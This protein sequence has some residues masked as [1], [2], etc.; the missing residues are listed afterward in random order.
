MISLAAAMLVVSLIVTEERY[1]WFGRLQKINF[2]G[3]GLEFAP[4]G[5][6]SGDGA[7]L[8]PSQAQ[9]QATG[10]ATAN[11]RIDFLL[12]HMTGW[13]Q[14][15][16]RDMQFA[17]EALQPLPEPDAR[18]RKTLLEDERL[19]AQKVI[20]PLGRLLTELQNSRG[21]SHIAYLLKDASMSY[22]RNH[23]E[24]IDA[25]RAMARQR[26][27]NGTAAVATE[28]T[29]FF[30]H[31]V[32]S[33]WEALCSARSGYPIEE[34]KGCYASLAEARPVLAQ[35]REGSGRGSG[36]L[37]TT[38]PYA[39]MLS[40]L[41]LNAAGQYEAA[42]ADLSD[43]GQSVLARKDVGGRR[44]LTDAYRALHLAAILPL[45]QRNTLV[46]PRKVLS[47]HQTATRLGVS[48]YT[49]PHSDGGKTSW[50]N[51]SLLLL[52]P[53]AY[54]KS[55]VTIWQ[56][57]AC[58]RQLTRPFKLFMMAQLVLV[59]NITHQLSLDRHFTETAASLDELR[60][61]ARLLL[62]PNFRCLEH[63]SPE[64]ASRITHERVRNLEGVILHTVASAQLLLGRIELEKDDRQNGRHRLCQAKA[65]LGKALAYHT[66]SRPATPTD[67]ERTLQ[68][69][70]HQW[71]SEH[72]NLLHTEDDIRHALQIS[73]A[74]CK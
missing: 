58:S 16:E 52:D 12:A 54:L 4:L 70:A 10:Y 66:L 1:G 25:A 44:E 68:N 74:D 65:H 17:A 6:R 42:V 26:G 71:I 63:P 35:L 38:L 45:F 3:G 69:S 47:L 73:S 50:K 64:A 30:A 49:S 72:V 43:W 33:L 7:R 41:L 36:M 59:N 55:D 21:Y 31:G 11:G 19:L 20:V 39:T 28:D 57:A 9:H 48:I 23:R 60:Q 53:G 62:L 56:T 67:S 51:Q 40:A 61:S 15:I 34:V 14:L 27:R 29:R 24:L 22:D 32:E 2:G 5:A 8:Q 46:L 13:D 18:H 37:T